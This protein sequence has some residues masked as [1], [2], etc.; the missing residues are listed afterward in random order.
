MI[1]HGLAAP[2]AKLPPVTR[3]VPQDALAESTHD[4]T[5]QLILS[6]AVKNTS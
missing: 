2:M 5:G 3:G 1:A 6:V 4:V